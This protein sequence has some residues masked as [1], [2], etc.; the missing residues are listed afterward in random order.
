MHS[1]NEIHESIV[2][3]LDEG[4]IFRSMCL[5][6]YHER[7][8]PEYCV[9]RFTKACQW[10]RLHGLRNPA[11]VDSV[12]R[13]CPRRRRLKCRSRSRVSSAC[14]VALSPPPDKPR[15]KVAKKKAGKR[16][17]EAKSTLFN[18]NKHGFGLNRYEG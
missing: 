9:H 14:C 5:K 12:I 17:R 15:G 7:C 18:G 4:A 10:V 11:P 2:K 16:K 6:S 13:W 1:P 8:E 3:N